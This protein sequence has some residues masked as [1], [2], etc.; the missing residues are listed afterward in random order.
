MHRGAKY[1]L[2]IVGLEGSPNSM[3]INEVCLQKDIVFIYY[4]FIV[5]SIINV[6]PFSPVS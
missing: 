6:P 1:S 5:E 4:I 3:R 2:T